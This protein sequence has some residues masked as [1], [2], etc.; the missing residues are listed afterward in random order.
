MRKGHSMRTT[1]QRL[2]MLGLWSAALAACAQGNFRVVVPNGNANVEGNSSMMDVFTNSSFRMQMVFDASQFAIPEGSSGRINSISFRIDGGSSGDV[3]YSFGGGSVTASTT[4]RA[5]D[6]LSLVFAEN[7]GANAVTI[8]NGAFSFGGLQQPGTSPQPFGQ[9]ISATSPFWYVPSEG[10][11][12]LDIVGG[13][14]QPFFPGALDAQSTIGDSVSRVVAYHF[15]AESGTA[16]TL[17]L[18]T[19]FDM[20]VVPEPST[21]LLFLGGLGVLAL[22]R[23][24]P[25]R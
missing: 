7:V 4:P 14:G 17:G 23:A 21:G 15:L 20:T 2:G 8:R 6:S 9:T 11:L 19:R 25:R 12:L 5:P 24:R 10:N 3:L 16:D 1:S 18:V 13:A 22:M